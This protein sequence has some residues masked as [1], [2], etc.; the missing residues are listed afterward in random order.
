MTISA[1]SDQRGNVAHLSVSFN[2]YRFPINYHVHANGVAK[3]FPGTADGAER[4]HVY[5][6]EIVKIL[7]GGLKNV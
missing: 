2:E 1:Y 7:K 4:A 3:V 6:K 5:Y